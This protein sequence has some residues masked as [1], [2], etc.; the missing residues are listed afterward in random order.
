[1]ISRCKE[2]TYLD[3]RPVTEKDRLLNA[4]WVEGGIEAERALKEKMIEDEKNRMQ[5]SALALMR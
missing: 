3:Q 1:M 2:L 4:A 5:E